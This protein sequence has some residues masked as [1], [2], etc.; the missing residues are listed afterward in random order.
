[1]FYVESVLGAMLQ[2]RSFLDRQHPGDSHLGRLSELLLDL[3]EE[4]GV[5]TQ[6]AGPREPVAPFPV[7]DSRPRNS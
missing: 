2:L 3:V 6:M 1:M 7:V 5:R 4:L